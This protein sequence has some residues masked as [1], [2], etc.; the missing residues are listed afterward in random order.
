LVA[1]D[2]HPHAVVAATGSELHLAMAAR[3]SLGKRG[4][5]LNVVSIPCVEL[6]HA[7]PSAYHHELFPDGVRVATIEAGRTDP[8]RA[9]VGPDGLT[10]GIDRYGASAPGAVNGEKFG[11]TPD[12][13]A[14]KI[15]TWLSGGAA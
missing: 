5:K 14:D 4:M 1:G 10:I 11:F 2:G 8:W 12:A 13:V 3:E 9:L 7:Q 15:A 6:L